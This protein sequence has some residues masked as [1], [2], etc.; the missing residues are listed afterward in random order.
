MHVKTQAWN[1]RTPAVLVCLLLLSSWPGMAADVEALYRA[2]QKPPRSASLMPYWFW[3]GP[4]TA[5]ASRRQMQAMIAQGVHQAIVFPWDGLGVRYLSEEYCQQVGAALDGAKELGFTLNFADEYDWPSGHAWDVHSGKPE[6]SRVLQAHPEFRMQRLERR[7]Q[8]IE[9]PRNWERQPDPKLELLV[10]AREE[11]NGCLAQDSFTILPV[12]GG[13]VGWDVPAGR[14]VI[15]AYQLT[16]GVGAHNTRLDLLNPGATRA[17]LDLVYEEY[18][19][20]FPQHLGTTLKLTVADHEGAYGAR[21]AFTPRLWDEFHSRKGYDLRRFLP[22]LGRHATDGRFSRRVR[23]DYFEVVSAL[24]A[25]SFTRQVTDWCSRHGLQHAMSAYEEQVFIQVSEGG[26]MYENWRGGTAVFIDA[27]LERA[28]MPIDFKEA[29]SVAHFDQKPLLVENQ[30]LQ[31]HATFFSLE[32]ARLGSNMALLWGANRLIPYFDYDPLKIQWPPQ[33]FL[34]QP[35]WRYFGHYAAMVN[36]AQFMNGQ[37]AHVAPVLLYYPRETAFAN[38]EVFFGN[39]PP[40][41]LRWNNV[42][43]R[44]QN[45]YSALQLELARQGWDYHIADSHYLERAE[46]RDQ[47]LRLADERFRVLILP[48]LTDMADG[49]RHQVRRFVEAGGVVLAIG[50]LPE[51]LDASGI[52]VFPARAHEPFQDRL[53]Y[54]EYLQTPAGIRE[55]LQPLFEAL[56]HVEPPQAEVVSEDRDRLYFSHRRQEGV[57]WYWIV[58]DTERDRRAVLRFAGTGRFEKW[59]AESGERRT[60]SVQFSGRRSD[61]ELR[62]GPY[63]AFFVVRHEGRGRAKQ[64]EEGGSDQTLLT[65]PASDWRF[66]PEA[67]RVEVPYASVEGETEPLWLAPER[68]AQREWWLIGPFA[69]DDHQGFFREFPPEREFQPA[70]KYL[71]AFGEVGWKWCASTDYIVRPREALGLERASSFGVYYA[72]AHVWSPTAQRAT[73]SVAFADSLSVWWNDEL[74]LSEHRHPKWLLLRDCWAETRALQVRP[75]WNTVRLKLGPSLESQTAFLFRL[76]DESGATLR[77]V[78]YAR[79]PTPAATTAPQRKRLTVAIPP[80]ATALTVPA[81]HNP[82]R[83]LMDGRALVAEPATRLPL[84]ASARACVFEIE[85]G[86]EPERPVAFPSG[87]GP[88]TLQSW[89]DSALGNYSGTALYET[90][91]ELPRAARGRRLVLDLGEVGL[92][93][94]VWVNGKKAGERAW[95]PFRFDVTHGVRPGK[96]ALRIRVANSNA[97]WLAQGGTIYSKGS[98]GLKYNTERDR[99]DTLR[100]NGLEGPV[101]L[102]AVGR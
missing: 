24:Y 88:F 8:V 85:S 64:P 72:F 92:A 1:R 36:R 101:R 75:G 39:Q 74:K 41:G 71:G 91:F 38:S 58:N 78:V 17:Y 82:F 6:L 61:V 53:D 5:A 96:N 99:L 11:A 16:P 19:R 100:P 87:T 56:K 98:W 65:L 63:D 50:E 68:L 28:R 42:M 7:E 43:D 84:P 93:A 4:I 90:E 33:W 67:A 73:L 48:P 22:L 2:F 44:V 83:L 18:A 60:L 79:D 27:L 26:D 66:T 40:R 46:I 97:G 69:Y 77:D 15:T 31:G 80:G 89:T 76:T 47:A 35:L 9:G 62:F 32:K 37:G 57:D 102:V 30:G 34:G 20:R 13:R 21:I 81:F 3:N 25:N 45:F 55:D 29:V 70:S 23:Q 14:W 94:E 52:R 54:L 49:A 51:G 95:R 86:D 10:A 59:D 12:S